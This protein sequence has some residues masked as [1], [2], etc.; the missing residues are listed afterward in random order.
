[1]YSILG[2]AKNKARRVFKRDL[3]RVVGYCSSVCLA[4]PYGR[5]HLTKLYHDLHQK[6]NWNSSVQVQLS[7]T[8]I[9]EL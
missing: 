9:K 2:Q 7:H 4:L 1:M 3:A 8:S 6:E 5:Y